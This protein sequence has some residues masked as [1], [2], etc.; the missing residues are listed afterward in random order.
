MGAVQS[1]V[2]SG[3]NVIRI[4]NF[5]NEEQVEISSIIKKTKDRR[6]K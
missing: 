2:Y 5:D 1:G 3:K 4:N 6:A